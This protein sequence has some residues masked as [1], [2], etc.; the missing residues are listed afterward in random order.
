MS[1]SFVPI[2][3]CVEEFLFVLVA[4]HLRGFSNL[5]SPPH[6]LLGGGWYAR[7]LTWAAGGGAGEMSALPM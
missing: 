1:L 7:K 2:D 3:L 6:E 4:W 5:G